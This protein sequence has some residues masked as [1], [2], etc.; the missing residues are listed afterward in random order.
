MRPQANQ[1]EGT[2]MVERYGS[3]RFAAIAFGVAYLAGGIL[4][5]ELVGSSADSTQTFTDHFNDDA[6]RFGDIAGAVLLVV[7]ALFAV[8]LG[9][10]LRQRLAGPTPVLKVDLVAGLAI[11]SAAG[12]L[13]S[14]GL[15]ITAP[16]WQSFGDFFDDP[17]MEP[18]VAAGVAQAGIAALLCSLLVLGAWTFLLVSL[19]RRAGQI[20]GW[21][22][23]VGWVAAVLTLFGITGAAAL[24]IGLWWIACGVF[25]RPGKGTDL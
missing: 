17:G 14:A 7:A 6:S 24:P 25:W 22:S 23:I 3:V 20:P 1:V 4:L 19:A 2:G 9:L 18:A 12:L 11:L 5:G 21:L 15:L 16:L 10:T 8:P 13:I